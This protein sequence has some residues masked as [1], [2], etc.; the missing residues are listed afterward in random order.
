MKRSSF[1]RRLYQ[2]WSTKGY[3]KARFYNEPPAQY[4]CLLIEKIFPRLIEKKKNC[5]L[6]AEGYLRMHVIPVCNF[7]QRVNLDGI[8]LK[9][10]RSWVLNQTDKCTRKQSI[11]INQSVHKPVGC[12]VVVRGL[13]FQ[14][15]SLRLHQAVRSGVVLP[16]ETP[17]CCDCVTSALQSRTRQENGKTQEP[18]IHQ[19]QK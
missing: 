17:G 2:C 19:G 4:S 6:A 8:Q 10:C 18:C 15:D 13:H 7:A 9:I 16:S 5:A 11:F 1:S 3:I 14:E 12:Y